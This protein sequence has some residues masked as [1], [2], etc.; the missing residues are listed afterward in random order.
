MLLA[1]KAQK[2]CPN[3][4]AQLLTL[5]ENGFVNTPVQSQRSAS[6]P[7]LKS[8]TARNPTNR[9]FS[10]T[11]RKRQD[12]KPEK[13]LASPENTEDIELVVRQA[14]HQFGNTLPKGYLNEEELKLYTRL[15]GPPL[16]ETR[17]ED[18]GMPIT[19]A[20]LNET[21]KYILVNNKNALF[22]ENEEGELE[23]I[24]YHPENATLEAEDVVDAEAQ[25][26]EFELPS[27]A[28]IDYIKAVAKNKREFYALMKLQKD[29]E[30][31]SLLR[32]ET[33]EIEAQPEDELVVDEVAE[34]EEENE[35]ED[36]GETDPE[37][38]PHHRVHALTEVGQWR[39]NPST[40]HFPKAQFINPIQTILGRTDIKHVKEA[41]E[42]AF[43]GLGLP[44]S[45]ATPQNGKSQ[46]QKPIPMEAG[47]H[48]MSEIEADAFIATNLP[49]MYASVMS[50][51]VEIRKRMGPEWIQGL[52]SRSN[53]EGPRVLDAGA[54]GAGL[55]AW[56]QVLQTEWELL[57]GVEGKA[58]MGPP[59][60][61]TVVVG[62]DH[63]RHRVSRFLNN[64]T[65][66]PRLPDYLHSGV[67]A[68]KMDDSE[69]SPLRKS[70]D[71][72]IASHLIMPTKTDFKRRALLDNI[73]EMLSPDGGILIVLEKGHPRGFEAVAD[74]RHR[75]INEFIESP[76]SDPQPDDLPLERQRVREPG[77]IIAPCTTHKKC[78]M[79]STPG[80]AHGRKDFCRFSQRFIRPP[81]LQRILGATHHN[82]E[83]VDFSFVAVQRGVTSSSP[84]PASVEDSL[85]VNEA[86]FAGF[87]HAAEP[88]NPLS[89]PR[90]VQPPLKRRGHV[91]LDLCTPA[92]MIERWTVPKSFSRQAYH[93]ARKTKWGDL[94][95]L[96]AKTRV[97]RAIRLGKGGVGPADDGIRARRAEEAAKGKGKVRVINLDS[98]SGGLFQA[99]E[100]KGVVGETG[101]LGGRGPAPA[102][103]RTKGGKKLRQRKVS[104]L[105]DEEM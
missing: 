36:E 96:G 3:C 85:D 54:G 22:R 11:K 104:N 62:S 2:A 64:T 75:L 52:L 32:P 17:P 29:F 58:A 9:S 76:T 49:G 15:Y 19:K 56:E 103:R 8:R 20:L 55:A 78:P 59:G 47:H 88:P 93:D 86:A 79:Y 67:L 89:L 37:F 98:D 16:R 4:R 97:V 50:I 1:R 91:T 99:S 61:K 87:E 69:V 83:D 25:A 24:P 53:G 34:Q 43:G 80:L 26:E 42:K 66:L 60:K 46:G 30:T 44:H 74:F 12:A 102:E 71:I 82:H 38:D 39:T 27:D 45:V 14:K 5:F 70:Y 10:T 81:F 35:E 23:E 13:R 63:L 31:A 7:N 84:S 57:H 72:I 100:K 33:E 40:M 77:M 18:V 65:F 68:E 28:G 101:R 41:A 73:W 90:N 6:F 51:L 94:W 48:K 92:G 95:A 105:L 21:H